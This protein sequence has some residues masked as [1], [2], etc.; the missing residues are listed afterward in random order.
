MAIEFIVKECAKNEIIEIVDW[1]NYKQSGLGERFYLDLMIKFEKI[2]RNP[3]I[4]S[5]YR[6]DFRRAVIKNFPYIVIFKVAENEIV[7][8]TIIY[9]GRDPE[10]INKRIS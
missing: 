1:Y 5:F 4:Y 10:L 8:Y 7:V 2:K 6:K 3:S 9:G